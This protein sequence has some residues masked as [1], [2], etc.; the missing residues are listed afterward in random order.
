MASKLSSSTLVQLRSGDLVALQSSVDVE[1]DTWITG[2]VPKRIGNMV[3][4]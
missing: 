4:I 2:L 1:E 3:S